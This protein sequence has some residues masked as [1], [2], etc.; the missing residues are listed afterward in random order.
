[1]TSSEKIGLAARMH[2]MLRRK[3]GRVTDTEWMASNVD[4]AAEIVRFA[5]D[6]AAAEGHPDLAEMAGKLAQAM[7]PK[8]PEPITPRKPDLVPESSGL[9]RYV[10]SLR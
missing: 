5:H 3:T 8:R 7:L 2:V 1:M 6:Y 10:K 9:V 4:Y